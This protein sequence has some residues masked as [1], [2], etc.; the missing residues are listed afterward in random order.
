MKSFISFKTRLM[1]G[2]GTIILLM[3]I[4]TGLALEQFSSSR[5]GM[6][7]LR[8]LVSPQAWA[9]E[10]MAFDVVQVQQ[11]LTDV[12]ATHNPRGFKE[13]QAYADDFKKMIKQIHEYQLSATQVTE[14]AAIDHAF[15]SFYLLGKRMA[16]AYISDGLQAG[17]VM[18]VEF[19]Q[20]SLV[21]AG[22]MTA[23][24]DTA[25]DNEKSITTTLAQAAE[26]IANFMWLTSLCVV[27][28]SI[29]IA[30]Y[31]TNYL[32][33]QLGIDPFYAKGIAQEI[34]KG[35]LD[36]SIDIAA[37][38][39]SS[40]LYAMKQ[41]QQQILGRI[42]TANKLIEEVTRIKI[43]L[44][45]VSTGVMIADNERTIIYAN[46]AV[47][48]LLTKIEADIRLELPTFSVDKLV[49][50]N[51]DQ[52]HKDPAHQ[53]AMLNTATGAS[54]SNIIVH[55]HHLV[56]TAN[57]VF[58][59]QGT[60]LGTA[61]EWVDRTAEV[62]VEIKVA[63]AIKAAVKGDFSYYIDPGELHGFYEQAADGINQL[64]QVCNDGL[65]EV[66]RVLSAIAEGDLTETITNEYSGTFGQLKDNANTT[67]EK[68]KEIIGQ[69]SDVSGD[70][71][72]GAK[73]IASGNNDLS[74][75]TEEQAASLEQTAASMHELTVTVHNNAENAKQANVMAI[76][77][78]SIA[79]KGGEV[80]NQVVVTMEAIN[81]SSRK[82]V[83]IISVIDGI[84]F[85]TNILALNAAVE[86]ARAGDQGKGF[87]VVAIEVRNL[88]QRAAAAAAEIKNLISDSVDKVGEG[89]K[90]VNHA[91]K[92]MTEIVNSIKGVTVIMA[93]IS[94][95]SEEQGT[96]IK[97]VNQAIAQMDNVT[98]QN[99]ALV[100]QAAAAAESLEEQAK[101]LAV[102][103][104][105]F[106]IDTKQRHIP[107]TTAMLTKQPTLARTAKISMPAPK[108]NDDW[109]EF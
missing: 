47:V 75:R 15:D 92:T 90:L 79:G 37:D 46:Q 7:E 48:N 1:I 54:L 93:N 8:D 55:G 44:D 60:R 25:V 30:L 29:F 42:T 66:V 97:Q 17:N 103:V 105:S 84:A 96:G 87:A 88:A 21:L 16:E 98:Q 76:S 39:K 95:A 85:Q 38:D 89:S 82:I 52:F 43:A 24:R 31:L 35:N 5:K 28:A 61:A 72:T 67:V 94:K 34:A 6:A 36:R 71:N 77:A 18:M 70:I 26:D 62:L 73:E 83:D 13:A 32:G 101:G 4:L 33:R 50:S 59:E 69:I 2:F 49:G 22:R 9:A 80:V 3:V 12:S 63:E 14:L 100:E 68:L 11:F 19:D 53:E 20:A 107:A 86:A 99:A 56:V 104:G 78:A 106:K 45:N 102:I 40:L 74:Q 51:I 58:D 65:N 27:L 81:E 41:M 57:P 109:E 91:G 64:M 23:F 10:K 108:A